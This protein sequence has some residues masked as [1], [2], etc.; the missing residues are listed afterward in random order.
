L[1]SLNTYIPEMGVDLLGL[2][3]SFLGVCLFIRFNRRPAAIY[4]AFACFVLALFTKQTMIAAPAACLATEVITDHRKAIRHFLFCIVLGSGGLAILAWLTNGEALRHLFLYNASQPFSLAHWVIGINQNLEDILP[5]AIVAC[6]ALFPLVHRIGST[7]RDG[8]RD[9]LVA[10]FRVSSYRLAMFVFGLQL[11]FALVVSLTYG[12][13]GSGVHYFLEWNFICC[14]LAALLFVR[15]L[16]GWRI[17]LRNDSSGA[18][19]F[20]LVFAAAL[21][22]LPGSLRRID[23]VYRLTDGERRS[24]DTIYAS[25]TAVLK[26]IEQTPGPVLCEN[27]LLVMK[28]NKEIPIEPGIQG[29][30]GK[31]GIWD[32]SGFLEMIRQQKFGVIIMRDLNPDFWTQPVIQAI[33]DHYQATEQI[34]DESVGESSYT[35]FRP[36][37]SPH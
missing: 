23:T 10:S 33:N 32:E 16:Y 11:L 1:G 25:D 29:F 5:I 15:A 26:I 31:A 3:F 34:G 17:S 18:A 13:S 27:M 12:K 21:T 6:L 19:I 28:A 4:V 24:Q 7:R 20:L 9:E 14:E 2:F 30:L 35:V 22:G 8:F 37:S 36:R